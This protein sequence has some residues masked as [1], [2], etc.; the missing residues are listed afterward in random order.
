[1]T[2]KKQP[3]IGA[4]GNPYGTAVPDDVL[5]FFGAEAPAE[6]P[7]VRWTEE[8][9]QAALEMERQAVAA[10]EAETKRQAELARLAEA[11]AAAREEA[12][13][14]QPKVEPRALDLEQE[15][16]APT[17]ARAGEAKTFGQTIRSHWD[18]LIDSLGIGSKAKADRTRAR[19]EADSRR[20]TSPSQTVEHPAASHGESRD[21]STKERT[22]S[23]DRVAPAKVAKP[24]SNPPVPEEIPADAFGFGI[25]A[26]PKTTPPSNPLDSLFE[27]PAAI[28]EPKVTDSRRRRSRPTPVAAPTPEPELEASED[29][30]EFEVVDLAGDDISDL[31]EGDAR[32]NRETR[33]RSR[34]AAP[35][36]RSARP[37]SDSP[38]RQ[39]PR[40][41][42]PARGA[43]DLEQPEEV[44]VREEVR[45][46]PRA[47]GRHE[48]RREPR[49]EGRR[50]PRPEPRRETRAEEP[51]EVRREPRSDARRP[52]RDE[53]DRAERRP[54]RRPAASRPA[55]VPA[56]PE[57]DDDGYTVD[58]SWVADDPRDVDAPKR[59]PVPTWRRVVDHIVDRN[60][61]N[62]RGG[63][64]GG[65]G[66]GGGPPRGGAAPSGRPEL[67]A[68]RV[69]REHAPTYL[70]VPAD[71]FEEAFDDALIDDL[72][73]RGTSRQ[74]NDVDYRQPPRSRT[75][76]VSDPL[77]RSRADANPRGGRRPRPVDDEFLDPPTSREP[78]RREATSDAP[79]REPIGREPVGRER[80]ARERVGRDPIDRESI[81]REPPQPRGRAPRPPAG[82]DFD[83]PPPGRGRRRY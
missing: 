37:E 16:T 73:A 54:A 9:E 31:W 17:T 35:A 21:K 80:V 56:P 64:G 46:E 15:S 49:P 36:P 38:E 69:K 60:L 75:P 4:L 52:I 7:A 30:I 53:E 67:P 70:D 62:R 72:P 63:G 55:P 71:D 3:T 39:R 40:T 11:E 27:T 74:R 68:T 34:P 2:E 79:R 83:G 66:R 13:R 32:S 45:R 42:K 78:R 57:D 65:R 61:S 77:D 19:E 14:N 33:G 18:S 48:V 24:S 51:V 29:E 26:N 58:N 82:D 81:D 76:E 8:Q 20:T 44:V 43:E 23:G 59:R 41:R 47:E 10:R 1:M 22:P 5:N 25:F 50:E 12:K 28:D 6:Q